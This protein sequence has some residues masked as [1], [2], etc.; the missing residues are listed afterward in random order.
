L[1]SGYQGASVYFNLGNCYF[2]QGKLGY[3]ILNYEKAAKLSPG[4]DEIVHNL[5][6]ANFR[7]IDK[8]QPIPSFFLFRYWDKLVLAFSVSGW[9]IASFVIYLLLLASVAVYFV[10]HITKYQ[11]LSFITGF[12]T[13]VFFCFSVFMLWQRVNYQQDKSKGIIVAATS[14]AKLAPDNQS[15]DSFVIHE[16]IKVKIED[17]VNEWVKIKLMDGKTGWVNGTN[18]ET[19]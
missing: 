6:I 3:A 2:R 7:T 10:S 19:I 11:R 14:V 13:I 17:R 9:T 5:K 4:D 8:V 1:E 18:I 12:F 16:G 15:K